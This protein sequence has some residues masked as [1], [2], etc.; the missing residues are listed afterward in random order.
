M[1]HP[2]TRV[3]A[4]LELLQSRPQL[5]GAELAARLEVDGRTVRRYITMLQDLGIPIEAVRGR[6]GAYRLRPGFKLPPL[7]F[8]EDEALALTLGLLVARELGLA[9]AALAVESALAKIERVLPLPLQERVRAVIETLVLDIQLGDSRPSHEVVLALSA[10]IK[11]D[12]RVWLRSRTERGAA[13]ERECD[14]YALVYRQGRWYLVGYCHLRQA[15]RLFRLDRIGAVE[16]RDATFTRPAN[17]DARRTVTQS[18]ANLPGDWTFEVL[19]DTTLAQAQAEFSPLVGTL[20]EVPGGVRFHGTTSNLPWIARYLAW[21]N[22][23]FVIHHPPELR[24]ALH[25]H[26]RTLAAY[27]DAAGAA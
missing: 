19:L 8:G 5:S 17:F 4:T 22:L 20:T 9:V 25:A 10:A 13:S 24:A 23:P 11:A 2:T 6:Y 16:P 3:L 27:A 21:C 15:Q 14:P 18:I 12:R 1:Y 26:A 7:M